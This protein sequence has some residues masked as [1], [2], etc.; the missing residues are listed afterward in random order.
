LAV[1]DTGSGIREEHRASIFDPFFTTKPAGSG[2]GWISVV[3]TSS[4]PPVGQITFQSKLG[5][6][7]PLWYPACQPSSHTTSRERSRPHEPEQLAR[8]PKTAASQLGVE[9]ALRD[10]CRCR[11]NGGGGL[12]KVKVGLVHHH[13]QE[14][15]NLG[16]GVD[17]GDALATM[18]NGHLYLPPMVREMLRAKGRRAQGIS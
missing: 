5:S 18:D 16:A 15:R 14:N 17:P 1:T 8:G 13:R 4:T 7:Q 9:G 3:R 2:P 10:A 12:C 11:P 6:G